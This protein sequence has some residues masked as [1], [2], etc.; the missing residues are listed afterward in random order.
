MRLIHNIALTLILLTL[1]LVSCQDDFDYRSMPIDGTSMV[2]L[3]ID[4]KAFEAVDLKSRNAG[5]RGDV[6]SEIDDVWVLI[7]D[8]AGDLQK[9]LCKH[10]TNTN[11]SDQYA[12][13]NFSLNKIQE[14]SETDDPIWRATM[15]MMLPYGQYYIVA[16]ANYP[17]LNPDDAETLANVAEPPAG[18]TTLNEVKKHRFPK[19]NSDNIAANKYMSG[20]FSDREE[21]SKNDIG[22]TPMLVQFNASTPT[23]HCWLRRAV[24]KVTVSFDNDNLLDNVT[25]YIESIEIKDIPEYGPK[26]LNNSLV[27]KR[28]ANG[29]VVHTTDSLLQGQKLVFFDKE[30]PENTKIEP[31]DFYAGAITITKGSNGFLENFP[32]PHAANADKTLFFYE[33]MQGTGKDKAQIVEGAG[34]LTQPTYPEGI[35]PTN[36][37]FKDSKPGG[38]YIQV[39]AYYVSTLPG[40][41]GQ[42]P[43]V[44]RFMLGKD[45]KNDYN[46]ERNHHYK[47]TLKFNGYANDVDWHIEYVRDSDPG[48][49]VPHIWVSYLYHQPS[50]GNGAAVMGTDSYWEKCYPI[51]ITGNVDDTKPLEVRIIESNWYPQG[52]DADYDDTIYYT[53]DVYTFNSARSG[54]A[55]KPRLT[56]TIS[57]T[58]IWSGFFSLYIP[59]GETEICNKSG[60]FSAGEYL[61]WYAKGNPWPNYENILTEDNNI[62][63]MEKTYEPVPDK[64]LYDY[65]LGYRSYDISRNG[66]VFDENNGYY[67]VEKT[68]SGINKEIVVY[69]PIFTRA[70]EINGKKAFSGGNPYFSF[71]R[72]G[73]IKASATFYPQSEGGE[74]YVEEYTA[75]VTQVR[76]IINPKL[77]LRSHDNTDDFTVELMHRT[78]ERQEDNFTNFVSDGP[79]R[80]TLILGPQGGWRLLGSV[81][82]VI[83]GEGGSNISFKVKPISEIPIDQTRCAIVKVEYHNYHCV[84]YI[85]LRQGYAPIQL[86]GSTGYWH[87]F[88]LNY[89]NGNNAVF[90]NCP[91]KEGGM[92]AYGKYR[93]I[94]PINNIDASYVSPDDEPIF[95]T[96][97]VYPTRFSSIIGS[98]KLLLSP[99]PSSK[100]ANLTENVCDSWKNIINGSGVNNTFTNLTWGGVTV[101][102]PKYNDDYSGHIFNNSQIEYGFGLAFADGA[103]TNKVDE[104]DDRAAFRHVWFTQETSNNNWTNTALWGIDKDEKKFGMRVCVVYNTQTYD[105]LSL[106]IGYT[107]FG[108]RKRSDDVTLNG[109]LRY[110][111]FNYA[112]EY[113]QHDLAPMLYNLYEQFGAI[114]WLNDKTPDTNDN[115]VVY[116][117]MDINYSTYDFGPF[118]ETNLFGKS[119]GTTSDAIFLRMVQ[120]VPL[121][122]SQYKNDHDIWDALCWKRR[123]L[124]PQ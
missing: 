60:R 79:W 99:V 17:G 7:Y 81:N 45:V 37:Y 107:G 110:G 6:I 16:V 84:H 112:G 59:T 64:S 94:D 108:R 35:N 83:T 86:G 43:I 15:R 103:K 18:I 42:G 75:D 8:E 62:A 65:G 44:Y 85:H 48:V 55:T 47:L 77:I 122:E 31:S 57:G 121:Q 4:F 40:N 53:G 87:S 61:Y 92:F 26:I 28:D 33:N 11:S 23:L 89:V 63:N 93:A 66:V 21:P 109:V 111:D 96:G 72:A 30:R 100:P 54:N 46:A 91:L 74:P 27:W 70:L 78:G 39:N 82:N 41:V 76:R 115:S 38:T 2:T 52:V 98:N 117:A 90:T 58:G 14:G 49:Y 80:A 102:V 101:R 13:D 124:Y 10:F 119:T 88:N 24:S 36:A 71:Q 3:N 9:S 5:M 113:S 67:K 50:I 25:I 118:P 1:S 106:P 19:W 12:S 123:R 120:D 73:K 104:G 20:W 29:D 95:K 22:E 69:I 68:G 51:R 34:D 56:E 114:Y 97:L 32:N 105:C 116:R